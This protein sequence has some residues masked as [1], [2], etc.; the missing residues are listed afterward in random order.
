MS[1]IF[2]RDVLFFIKMY[3]FFKKETQLNVI[4]R[5]S[6]MRCILN[7]QSAGKK[8]KHVKVTRNI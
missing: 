1:R 8:C 5:F 2:K 3:I 7:T 4:K 6:K